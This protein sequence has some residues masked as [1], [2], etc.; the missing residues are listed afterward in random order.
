MPLLLFFRS[1]FC[2]FALP[3]GGKGP[4]ERDGPAKCRLPFLW[5]R[6]MSTIRPQSRRR[7]ASARGAGPLPGG[8]GR[9]PRMGRHRAVDFKPGPVQPGPDRP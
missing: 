7:R 8:R 9:S 4:V 3:V 1:S 6:L 5:A 2:V